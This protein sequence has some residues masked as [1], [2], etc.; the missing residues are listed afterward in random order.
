MN[1][2]MNDPIAKSIIANANKPALTSATA[3]AATSNAPQTVQDPTL[4]TAK[5]AALFHINPDILNQWQSDGRLTTHKSG[6]QKGYS[7]NDQKGKG[8]GAKGTDVPE[9]LA[10][11]DSAAATR[12]ATLKSPI[13]D[14]KG[15][16][17]D[18]ERLPQGVKQERKSALLVASGVTPK[19]EKTKDLDDKKHPLA[20]IK[21]KKAEGHTQYFSSGVQDKI[22]AMYGNAIDFFS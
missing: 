16:Y 13:E 10:R 17:R 8:D 22:K 20:A 2:G 14:A 19:F 6:G 18:D 12:L 3:G 5:A 7:S 21:P 4:N 9:L 15:R 11:G 1:V